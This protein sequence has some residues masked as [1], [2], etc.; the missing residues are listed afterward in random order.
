MLA[1]RPR[2]GK[3]MSAQRLIGF[4][5]VAGAFLSFAIAWSL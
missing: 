1:G 5:I 2:E 4:A 3:T